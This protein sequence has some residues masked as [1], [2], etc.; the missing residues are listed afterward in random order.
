[1]PA[2][3]CRG[4]DGFMGTAQLFDLSGRVV[5][6]TGGTG[7]LGFACAKALADLGASVVITDRDQTECDRQ[8][9][10]LER[11]GAH[12]LGLGVDLLDPDS[13]RILIARTIER[14]GKL[15][16]LVNN[17]AYT[18]TTGVSGW[19]VP[20]ADQT[21]DAWNQAVAVNLTAPF[22]LAQAAADAL[23][24][25]GRGAIINV[26]S[27]YGLVA[28]QWSL[29]EETAMTNPAGYA[30]T[31][32]GVIQLTRYLATTLAPRVRVNAICPGGIER[33]QPEKFRA[34]Y[35][36]RTPLGRMAVETDMVGAFAFLASDASAY[37][38]GQ[39]LAIDGGWTAW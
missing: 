1:M 39:V 8:T 35:A 6:I 28:P 19:A 17:A 36:E 11:A 26:A 27:I 10:A 37:V 3:L 7:H 4:T 34:R 9:A 32:G 30:A 20:F 38:T 5:L 13:P 16:V 22:R 24:A 12:A 29:Y 31:K 33:G 18:G 21:L 14:F 23:A 15:D 2:A 25:S